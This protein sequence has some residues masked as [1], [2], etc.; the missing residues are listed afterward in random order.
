M[1]TNQHACTQALQAQRA[2]ARLLE[3]ALSPANCFSLLA[4]GHAHK[5]RRLEGRAQAVAL[6][7]LVQAVTL[8]RAG[9]C[10]LPEQVLLVF[11]LLRAAAIHTSTPVSASAS[12]C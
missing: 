4:L 11:P 1:H 9:F 8:D 2:C 3:A 12:L 5:L 10:S 6:G 7:A